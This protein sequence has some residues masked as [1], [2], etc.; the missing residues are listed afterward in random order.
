MIDD[1]LQRFPEILNML[2]EKALQSKFNDNP[3]RKAARDKL[4]LQLKD[5]SLEL[6]RLSKLQGDKLTNEQMEKLLSIPRP[7]AIDWTKIS[8]NTNQNK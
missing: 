1:L 5:I 4:L 2:I 8:Q 7:G 6:E 3:A